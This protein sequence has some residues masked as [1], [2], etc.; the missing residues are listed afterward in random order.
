MVSISS[1]DKY[2]IILL[3]QN[4]AC[5]IIYL[6]DMTKQFQLSQYLFYFVCPIVVATV[7]QICGSHLV[8][9]AFAST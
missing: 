8:P 1:D 6:H 4:G 2:L 9:I 3:N 7:D 5:H